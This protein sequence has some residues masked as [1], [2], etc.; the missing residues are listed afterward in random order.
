M[1][2]TTMVNAKMLVDKRYMISIY[3]GV[4]MMMV[5]RIF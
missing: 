4:R 2:G 3:I 5:S 1:V